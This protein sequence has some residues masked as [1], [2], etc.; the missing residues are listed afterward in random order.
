M[1]LR[2]GLYL[3]KG[4]RLPSFIKTLRISKFS[5]S[6]LSLLYS[7]SPSPSPIKINV[8]L[9]RSSHNLLIALL[10]LIEITS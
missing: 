7:Y 8:L 2:P 9:S 5:P 10:F 3:E 4:L 6:P 1:N